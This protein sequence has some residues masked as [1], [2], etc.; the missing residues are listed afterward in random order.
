MDKLNIRNSIE[1]CL[2]WIES[3]MLTYNK[4]SAGVYERIRINVNERVCWTRP[5]CTSEVARAM[6]LHKRV[7]STEKYEEIY[8]NIVNWL[9]SVQD[10]D[11]FSAWYGSFPFYLYDGHTIDPGSGSARYQN[12]NAKVLICLLDLYEMTGDERLLTSACKLSDYWVGIQRPEGYFY[13]KDKFITQALY[14]G[15]CFVFWMAAGLMQCYANSKIEKYKDSA[16]KALEYLLGLQLENGRFQTTYEIH[17][18]EDWRPVSSENAIAVFCL[19][20]ILKYDFSEQVK[21][22]LERVTDFLISL[23]H[24]SGAIINCNETCMGA[25]LQENGNLC[26][27][28][29]TEGFALMGFIDAFKILNNSEYLDAAKKLGEFLVNIQCKDESPLWDGG[30]R[31][32]YDVIKGCWAGRADQNNPIDEGGMYSVYTGWCAAPIMYGLL[33]LEE[34]I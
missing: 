1:K 21:I 8:A 23:Q 15:P 18:S 4:G 3:Q 25:S 20:R 27:L 12:D 34:L 32:S 29:Y 16:N 24:E 31:G 17:K 2:G 28:V 14:K 11:D 7:N 19:A 26:D 33:Q 13:R 5:D 30:W 10:N 9:L 22:A 6:K